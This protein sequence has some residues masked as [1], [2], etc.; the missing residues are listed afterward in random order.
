MTLVDLVAG[1]LAQLLAERAVRGMS[2]FTLGRP[3]ERALRRAVQLAVQ[4]V[5][6]ALDEPARGQ[7]ESVLAELSGPLE[8][9]VDARTSL[10]ETLSASI[11]ALVG[12]LAMP[13]GVADSGSY[14]D[15]IGVDPQWL[16]DTLT[17]QLV[18]AVKQVALQEP[19]LGPLANQLNFDALSVPGPSVAPPFLAPRPSA[20]FVERPELGGRLLEA[21]VAEPPPDA[22]VVVNGPG[23]FGKTRLAVWACHQ[24]QVRDRFPD[25]VLWVELGQRPSP[26]HLVATLADLAARLTGGQRSTYQTVP[27]AADAFAAALGQRRILLVIDD[28]WRQADVEPFLTGGPGCVRLVTTRRPPVVAGHEIRVDVMSVSEAADVLRRWVPE[29]DADALSPLLQ[30][31]GRWPLA[32]G[33]L[34]SALRTTRRHGVSAA[35]AVAELVAELD[36]RGVGVLDE[37][38]DRDSGRSIAATLSLSLDEL[39]ASAA[40]SLDRYVSLAAF[41]AGESVPGR[42]LER[43]WGFSALRVRAEIG[44]FFDRSMVVSADGVRLHDVVHDELRRRFPD[45]IRAASVAL[46][47]ACRPDGGWH[48]LP[49]DDEL[50]P[51]LAQHLVQ[52]GRAQ[53]LAELLRDQRYLVIRLGYSG[54]LALESDLRVYQSN[55]P[56]DGYADALASILRQEAHLLI[57]HQT[58]EDLMLAL[59]SRLFSRPDVFAELHHVRDAVPRRGLFA[60]HPL[61]DRADPRL[62][63][64]L[65]GHR[66]GAAAL[67][68]LPDGRLASVGELDNTLRIWNTGTGEQESVVTLPAYPLRTRL[69]PDGCHL[70]YVR[71]RDADSHE[72]GVVEVATGTVVADRVL[73]RT[74][75]PAVLAWGPAGTLAVAQDRTVVLWRPFEG[76]V[77]GVLEL[78]DTLVALAWHERSGLAGLTDGGH[79]VRWPD[80][81]VTDAAESL[82]LNLSIGWAELAWR[83]DGRYLAVAR[84]DQLQI[85]EPG[86]RQVRWRKPVSLRD[87]ETYVWRSAGEALTVSTY[88]HEMTLGYEQW[89]ER[90]GSDALGACDEIVEGGNVG[91]WDPSGTYLAVAADQVIQIWRPGDSADGRRMSEYRGF[92]RVVWQPAGQHLALE[93]KDLIVVSADLPDVPVWTRPSFGGRVC[94][95]PDGRLVAEGNGPL[96]IINA[97]TGAI[98]RE[99]SLGPENS[100]TSLVGWPT[101]WHLLVRTSSRAVSVIDAAGTHKASHIISADGHAVSIEAVSGDGQRVAV[102]YDNRLSA[103]AGLV[104]V[105][106]LTGARTVLDEKS[107]YDDVC[108]LPDPRRLVTVSFFDKELLLW[109][110]PT[111]RVIATF[112]CAE[113]M[114]R[115]AADPTGRYV[116]ALSIGAG[117][118]ALYD[119]QTLRRVCGIG[120]QGS[121]HACAFDSGGERLA[122]VGSAGLYLFR[123]CG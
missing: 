15:Q 27:V 8:L 104:V 61:P 103:R 95:S 89:N 7:L 6:D 75:Q 26:E 50:W 93:G 108:F 16:A 42:L 85:T 80:P 91:S 56:E 4:R 38:T 36:R 86:R 24:P 76:V 107:K 45:R 78:P 31:S 49:R 43:L 9:P 115:L 47:D 119:A 39:A 48:L 51:R 59:H 73:S 54:P 97:V 84:G 12:R 111:R 1:A 83:P 96:R 35:D 67:T 40:P 30:R 29:A 110:I 123:V 118:I 23:G 55:R 68:W 98:V 105:E 90:R 20:S 46:L 53:E 65:T 106:V 14:L 11:D 62:V 77:A 18:A 87:H 71:Q 113:F 58:G 22:P 81:T 34:A 117:K 114:S 102:P 94:W 13:S 116:A 17:A 21:L 5:V 66:H 79:L 101:P 74:W 10:L 3:G 99:V 109:D 92:S 37:L 2:G 100:W 60:A 122:V 64:V 72:V 44:R 88:R 57:G 112:R 70:S 121:A 41:G 19:A 63:R 32:L 25:G 82:D 33:F 69:S 28:A 120:V 52:A